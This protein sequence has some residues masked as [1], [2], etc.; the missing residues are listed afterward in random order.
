MCQGQ[1]FRHLDAD[2]DPDAWGRVRSAGGGLGAGALTW[3]QVGARASCGPRGEGREWRAFCEGGRPLSL[4]ALWFAL[5]LTTADRFAGVYRRLMEVLG[6]A[7]LKL[8]DG[9][10]CTCNLSFFVS[11]CLS[12]LAVS[13]KEYSTELLVLFFF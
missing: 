4:G 10:K 13:M 9:I 2:V 3:E 5:S 12:G 7:G 8:W 6:P 11:L 1:K